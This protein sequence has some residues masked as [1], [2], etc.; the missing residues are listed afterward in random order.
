M[1]QRRPRL[2]IALAGVAVAATGVALWAR[3]ESRV[4]PG[5]ESAVAVSASAS[6]SPSPD[7][8]T[9]ITSLPISGQPSDAAR[10]AYE[11]ALVSLRRADWGRA[12]AQL[13]EAV[14]ADPGFTQ[15][16]LRLAHIEGVFGELS[17][18]RE[19]LRTVA[20]HEAALGERDRAWLRAIEALHV[21]EPAD[22]RLAGQ[23]FEEA[24][25]RWPGDAELR[26]MVA[27][28]QERVF[29]LD[30]ALEQAQAAVALDP[31]YADALQIVARLRLRKGEVEQARRTLDQ[32]VDT[33]SVD[34]LQ[35]RLRMR[36][37][38]GQ[39]AEVI[40]DAKLMDSRG[41]R[42][43]LQ[44]IYAASA[45]VAQ[46]EPIAA[47]E[48]FLTKAEEHANTPRTRLAARLSRVRVAMLQGRF[49]EA[50]SQLEGLLA[51]A[52]SLEDRSVLTALST[53]VSLELED[54]KRFAANA[55]G[56]L[57]ARHAAEGGFGQL[58]TED[59]TPLLWWELSRMGRLPADQL[60]SKLVAWEAM[61]RKVGFDEGAIWF[62]SRVASVATAEEA[63]R[64]LASRPSGFDM[65]QLHD[66]NALHFGVLGWDA[67]GRAHR[68]A[69][70]APRALELLLAAQRSCTVLVYPMAHVRGYL[71]LGA[72]YEALGDTAKACDAYR[73][74]LRHWGQA[75]PGSASADRAR[76]RV[77]ALKCQGA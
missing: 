6:A 60:E 5:S 2:W 45:L 77:A 49:A 52:T 12:R 19:R 74:V 28:T 20:D 24:S 15:A 57:T 46:G 54:D 53:S 21:N 33:R 31:Q 71:E 32:C 39:C 59:P 17:R 10:Q 38:L 11:Q 36:A 66:D 14:K 37:R 3:H 1:K 56:F 75:L 55:E 26:F 42:G 34:C 25:Q 13:D 65:W 50:D 64:T 76:K 16:Q 48:G 63:K 61:R 29:K 47:A 72:T 18:A 58:P 40:A 62:Q 7:A 70:D 51:G 22:Y 9:P 35:D 69:G 43:V 23:R 44:W 30:G 8:P 27:A 4:A 73:S 41:A 67:L 68:L